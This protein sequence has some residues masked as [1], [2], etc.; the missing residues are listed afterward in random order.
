MDI[1]LKSLTVHS[2]PIH[3]TTVI[4]FSQFLLQPEYRGVE[5][6]LM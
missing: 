5:R 3:I 4:V 1:A 6:C 2:A